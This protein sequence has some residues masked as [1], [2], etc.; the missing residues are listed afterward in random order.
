MRVWKMNG[1]GNSFAVVDIRHREN[2]E[3]LCSLALKLCK[4]LDT[5]GFMALDCSDIADFKLH[6][7]NRD[8]SRA[9]MCGNGARC[10]CRFAYDNGIAG[11][12]MTLDSDAGIIEGE[13]LCEKVYR[14]RLSSP[15]DV[16]L[17]KKIGV[18][19]VCVGV[20]H[21]VIETELE[22]LNLDNEELFEIA[23]KYRRELDANVNFYSKI[24]NDCVRLLTYERGVENFTLACGTG[25]GAV[26][27]VL[28][29]RGKLTGDT[30]TVKNL[31][32]ELRVSVVYDGKSVSELYLEGSAEVDSIEEL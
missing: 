31:G 19:C 9:E 3:G 8:G 28:A 16:E 18:D 13:R 21:A 32:G 14:V 24:G 1:A 22:A 7:Y 26:A 23:R 12:R 29:I 4:T 17:D 25:S 10:I 5:D 11:E 15:T 20:R 27:T 2:A 6:F 30:L